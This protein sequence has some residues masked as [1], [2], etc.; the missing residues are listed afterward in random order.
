MR[1][2]TVLR[3]AQDIRHARNEHDISFMLT[4]KGNLRVGGSPW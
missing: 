2:V 3:Y 1:L 4:K